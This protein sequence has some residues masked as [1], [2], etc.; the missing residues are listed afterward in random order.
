MITIKVEWFKRNVKYDSVDYLC[1][2]MDHLVRII[3]K[4]DVNN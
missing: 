2:V 1:N 4:L 3:D